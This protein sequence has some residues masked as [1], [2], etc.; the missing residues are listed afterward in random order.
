MTASDTAARDARWLS[1]DSLDCSR[2][3]FDV[4]PKLSQI[5]GGAFVLELGFL[6]LA[7][8]RV[9]R[10]DDLWDLAMRDHDWRSLKS[11]GQS[12]T[13]IPAVATRSTEFTRWLSVSS[14]SE[15]FMTIRRGL[16]QHRE[17]PTVT[18]SEPKN[19]VRYRPRTESS[20]PAV[21]NLRE[22]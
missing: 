22:T 3:I 18:G 15:Y 9:L 11:T 19:R 8:S 21:R 7:A 12:A 6:D 10:R 13:S 20:L 17:Q 16:R 1:S 2:K 5:F 4:R 14:A